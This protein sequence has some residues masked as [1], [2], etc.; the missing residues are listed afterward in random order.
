MEALSKLNGNGGCGQ[1]IALAQVPYPVFGLVSGSVISSFVGSFAPAIAAGVC[2]RYY[3]EVYL[4]GKHF[5][6]S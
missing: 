2:E 5:H 3:S 6:P 4:I 1:A